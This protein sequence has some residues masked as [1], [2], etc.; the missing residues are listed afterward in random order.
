MTMVQTALP[1]TPRP[2][3]PT[4]AYSSTAFAHCAEA[5]QVLL[6]QIPQVRSHFKILVLAMSSA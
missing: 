5:S 3:S 4:S 6:L 2:P 1:V